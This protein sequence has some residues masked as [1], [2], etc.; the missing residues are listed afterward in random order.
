MYICHYKNG[1]KEMLSDADAK[2]KVKMDRCIVFIKENSSSWLRGASHVV[3]TNMPKI[4]EQAEF[5]LE[6]DGALICPA[7]KDADGVTVN[8]M[9][10]MNRG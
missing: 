8:L 3:S 9:D 2:Q 4:F 1:E 7:P 6:K 10:V 5:Y